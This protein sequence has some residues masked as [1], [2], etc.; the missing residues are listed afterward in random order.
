MCGHGEACTRNICFFAH[1]QHELR[2]PG[3]QPMQGPT[4]ATSLTAAMGQ[5]QLSPAA[6]G[7]QQQYQQ[8]AF[9][10]TCDPSPTAVYSVGPP[11]SPR[12]VGGLA[13]ADSSVSSGGVQG[14]QLGSDGSAVWL[15]EGG[16]ATLQQYQPQQQQQQQGLWV[17]APGTM[18]QQPYSGGNMLGPQHSGG[19]TSMEQQ[20]QQ[21]LVQYVM[22]PQQQVAYA[23]Y[24]QQ[25]SLPL[26][27][28]QFVVQ[29]GVMLQ[30]ASSLDY[31]QQLVGPAQPGVHC[32]HT[33]SAVASGLGP[34]PP[35]PSLTMHPQPQQQQQQQL[36]MLP[37]SQYVQQQGQGQAA[38]MTPAWSV[39][40]GGG[41]VEYGAPPG[42][43]QLVYLQHQ[44]Q[45]A[46]PP[47]S[48]GYPQQ[49][50]AV[51]LAPAAATSSSPGGGGSTLV[52]HPS[53]SAAPPTN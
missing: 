13:R 12:Q 49:Q 47:A 14:L 40:Q 18:Q 33:S 43:Q 16:G 4:E 38:P 37:A 31:Q 26:E 39:V 15:V 24:G 28:Q 7:S 8:P 3:S 19:M 35:P 22:Q 51:L 27:Q 23:A 53:A 32:V 46:A 29:G 30:H 20:Q 48:A 50:V 42:M 1:N 45:N 2:T 6:G 11:A 41:A 44:P 5:M 52:V 9:V 34:A 21:A 36:V 25:Q 17:A 10:T